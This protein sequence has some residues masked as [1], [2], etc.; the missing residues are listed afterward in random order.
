MPAPQVE[1]SPASARPSSPLAPR[2]RRRLR[3]GLAALLGAAVVS[4]GCSLQAEPEE[5][6]INDPEVRQIQGDWN[7]AVRATGWTTD[8]TYALASVE[9]AHR[10]SVNRERFAGGTGIVE[11]YDHKGDVIYTQAIDGSLQDNT[12]IAAGLGPYTVRVT[13][14]GFTGLLFVQVVPVRF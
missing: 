6:P 8:R 1:T 10:V 4:V 12:R 11:L 9:R 7:F 13:T 3:R 5:L 2:W 14:T